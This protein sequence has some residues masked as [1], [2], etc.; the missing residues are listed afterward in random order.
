M[1][2]ALSVMAAQLCLCSRSTWDDT[3][4]DGHGH[5]SKTSLK[6]VVAE[7]DSQAVV[8]PLWASSSGHFREGFPEVAIG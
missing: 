1:G 4:T 2:S 5:P 6:L 7:S 8:C 3:R